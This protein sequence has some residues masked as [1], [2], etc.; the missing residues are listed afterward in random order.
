MKRLLSLGPA[1]RISLGL[2]SLVVG[3]LMVMDLALKLLPDERAA[4][5]SVREQVAVNLA[6][7]VK[8]LMGAEPVSPATPGSTPTPLATL[9]RE[10]AAQSGDI[11]SL[12]VRQQDGTLLQGTPEHAGQ[13]VAP[14]LGLST[15]DHVIVP[16][17]AGERRWGQLEVRYRD[18]PPA[19]WRSWLHDPTVRLIATLSLATFVAF[20]LYLRRALQHLDPS[21]AIPDR[22]RAA[23]DTLTEGLLVLDVQGQILM[24][25][26]AF[27]GFHPQAGEL[28]LGRPIGQLGWLVQGLHEPAG[29]PP[30][31]R[32]LLSKEP[33]L[34]VEVDLGEGAGEPG[35]RRRALLNCAAIRDAAGNARGCLLTLDDVSALDQ[36]NARLRTTL[37][38]LEASRDQVQRQNEALQLLASR[39]PMTGCFNRRAF[40][41]LAEPMMAAARR[42]HEPLVCVMTDIDRFKSVNDTHG[43]TVGDQ[44]I[45]AVAKVLKAAMREEDLLCRYGG[46]EFCILLRGLNLSQAMAVAERIRARIEHEVGP[47]I[48]NVP[49]MRVSASFGVALMGQFQTATLPTLI[50]R[51]DQGLYAAKEAG[52]NRVLTLDELTVG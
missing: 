36:A 48:E 40:F 1:A 37:V 12:G 6:V 8:L 28:L 27:R 14:A 47:S 42:R 32:A 50:D 39:D 5:Q 49:G 46:E 10:V 41:E 31:E 15:L 45:Q 9:M 30:W 23:F 44:V 3:L 24:A 20:N 51:A 38:A 29:P 35:E 17:Y 22:V 2:V 25:N 33:I 26:A 43:H 18:A 7:Q 21:G 34:R 13:W 19:S 16:L 52:R 11:A 4:T